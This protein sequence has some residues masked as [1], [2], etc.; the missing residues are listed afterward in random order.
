MTAT[1]TTTIAPT[2]APGAPADTLQLFAR[3]QKDGDQSARQRWLSA[4]CRWPA[5]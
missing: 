3:W 1:A 2:S 4:S 5:A